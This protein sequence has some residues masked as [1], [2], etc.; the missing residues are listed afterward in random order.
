[1]S[2]EL[3]PKISSEE[4]FEEE[5]DMSSVTF[6]EEVDAPEEIETETPIEE[7]KVEET[8]QNESLENIENKESE[9]KDEFDI[10]SV[11]EDIAEAMDSYPILVIDDDKWI[12]RIFQQYL[13]LWGFKYISATDPF[14][15]LTE[16]LR[17]KP[18]M[19]FVD[20]MLPEM[21]GD[22]LVKFI[23]RMEATQKIPIVVISS[24]LNKEVIRANYI[25]GASGFISKPFEQHTLFNKI[26]ELLNRGV[27]NRMVKD[28]L[29]IPAK[30]KK[31]PLSITE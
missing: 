18:L 30:V 6:I 15:G 29:I 22:I 4:N 13:S 16:A 27:Y 2:E 8:N 26:K 10:Q 19:I 14:V 1:M 9:T 5:I 7:V 21:N 12:Q 20:V 23:R 11:E 25:A 24:N 28:E 17:Y 3:D 31:G